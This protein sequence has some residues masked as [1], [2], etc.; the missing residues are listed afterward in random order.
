MYKKTIGSSLILLITA[1]IWGFAFVAQK[2]SMDHIGPFTFNGARFTLGALCVLIYSLIADKKSSSAG[3]P[4][5]HTYFIAG[6]PNKTL[7]VAGLLCGL[8]MFAGSSFQ[9]VALQFTTAGK[10]AFVT[11]LYMIIV[12]ILSIFLKKKVGF[13][14]WLGVVLAAFGFY[15]LCLKPGELQLNGGDLL[16]LIGSIFWAVQILV[17]DYFVNKTDGIKMAAIQFIITAVLSAAAALIFEEISVATLIQAAVPILY[18]GFLSVGIAFTL[19]IVGQKNTPPTIASLILS[20]ESV[21]AVIGGAWLLNEA[22]SERELLGCLM[23]FGGV[24][25]AQIPLHLIKMKKL[26][27]ADSR[28]A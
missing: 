27:H 3:K 1:I 13:N 12:P 5:E 4:V 23:I 8:A 9:Q 18:G 20:L 2:T 26:S 6:K 28:D 19:Q 15:F 10:C 21:F 24:V 17:I 16:T 11:A 14:T 7:F 25:L 22:L